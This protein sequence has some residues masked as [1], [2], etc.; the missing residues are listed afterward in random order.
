MGRSNAHRTAQEAFEKLI[1][2]KAT[3]V[4]ATDQDGRTSVPEEPGPPMCYNAS[5]GMMVELS[6]RKGGGHARSH[7]GARARTPSQQTRPPTRTL[8]HGH[9]TFTPI[10]ELACTTLIGVYGQ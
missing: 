1:R 4:V 3:M 6:S 9:G 2:Q 5:T 8:H 10:H 7:T